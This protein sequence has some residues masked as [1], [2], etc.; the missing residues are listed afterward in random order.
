MFNI[1]FLF[2]FMQSGWAQTGK[3]DLNI[4]A[5]GTS[6]TE[7]TSPIAVGSNNTA[8][9]SDGTNLIWKSF[10]PG[11]ASSVDNAVAIWSGTGGLTL[12]NTT[13]YNTSGVISGLNDPVAAQDVATKKY[14]DTYSADPVGTIIIMGNPACP[15]LSLACDGSEISRTTYAN[16]Y[17]AIGTNWGAGDGSTTFNIPDLRNKFIKGANPGTRNVATTEAE[18][19]ISHTHTWSITSATGGAHSHDFQG[20]E[21]QNTSG[22]DQDRSQP[23]IGS[24]P[25]DTA[26]AAENAHTHTSGAITSDGTGGTELRMANYA[27]VF[28]IRY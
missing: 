28:C 21:G 11:L 22:S 17:T 24:D 8:L 4:D 12:T 3:I 13:V 26:S 16:L 10:L 7:Y 15:R 18:S 25:T 27:V 23:Y 19:I 20:A 5:G 1:I 2:Y 14:V 9:F 6:V